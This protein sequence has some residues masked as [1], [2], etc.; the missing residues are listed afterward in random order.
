MN[1]H[2]TNAFQNRKQN[3]PTHPRIPFDPNSFL[4][5]VSNHYLD[6]HGNHFLALKK[7]NSFITQMFM[8]RN[9]R[10]VFCF[11]KI[12]LL[13]LFQLISSSYTPFVYLQFICVWT[14][15]CGDVPLCE[16][17]WWHN[18]G[19]VHHVPL[20]PVFP[21]NWQLIQRLDKLRFSRFC[22][23]VGGIPSLVV[24][25]LAILVANVFNIYIYLF[26]GSWKMVIF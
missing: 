16:F 17:G 6:F 25:V 23:T 7:K 11:K 2:K 3:F 13:I 18:L 1:F 5:S 12:R 14:Q 8:P 26:T 22:K 21:A 20:S 19:A 15:A 4:F 10:W 24:S 9:Y